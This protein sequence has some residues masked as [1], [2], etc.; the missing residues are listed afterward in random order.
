MARARRLR[1]VVTGLLAIGWAASWA[2]VADAQDT[3]KAKSS[4]PGVGG[5]PGRSA[6]QPAAKAT[7]GVGR[8]SVLRLVSTGNPMLWPLGLCSI[9]TLGFVLERLIA[10][11]RER[12]IPRDFVNRF[13][14]RLASGKLDR[15]RAV[16]LCR[17]NDSP[18][19]RVFAHAIRYWGQ[20]AVSIRQAIGYD[21]AGELADLKRNVRVLNGTATLAPLLGLLGTVVGMI[22]SFDALSVG[23][24]GSGG[25]KGEQLAHGISLALMTTALGLAIA[26][27]S[28]TAYY[29]LLH[30]VDVLVRELDDQTL[31]VVDLVAGESLRPTSER[32][33]N[34]GPTD[35]TRLESRTLGRA[36]PVVRSEGV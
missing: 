20:P 36:D 22:E 24:H 34:V 30:R 25:G 26:V 17:A 33:T 16:E 27:I 9:V 11:R 10:L 32:W 29:Y 1:I 19:A 8:A 21:A 7:G 15:E 35:H 12:V 14:E 5:E 3:S 28:V 23:V 31:R 13:L 2:G 4:T 18:V 6:A